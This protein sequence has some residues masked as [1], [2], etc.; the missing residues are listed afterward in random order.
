[1]ALR[2]SVS[3][4]PSRF[5]TGTA[6]TGGGAL[7]AEAFGVV[8]E[9]SSSISIGGG[10]EGPVTCFAGRG[11]EVEAGRASDRGSGGGE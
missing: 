6:S 2:V 11:S 10:V 7:D 3:G 1:M 9:L 8:G 4:S 5:S